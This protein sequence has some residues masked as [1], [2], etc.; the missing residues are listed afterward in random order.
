MLKVFLL[1]VIELKYEMLEDCFNDM[2]A[3]NAIMQVTIT[4][5]EANYYEFTLCAATAT[6]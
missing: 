3:L 4:G 1:L 6:N 2:V 5:N